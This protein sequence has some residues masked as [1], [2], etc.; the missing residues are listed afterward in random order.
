MLKLSQLLYRESEN[1]PHNI[2]NLINTAWWWN[3]THCHPFEFSTQSF[4]SGERNSMVMKQP[5]PPS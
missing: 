1:L 3:F 5:Y 2:Y 4:K